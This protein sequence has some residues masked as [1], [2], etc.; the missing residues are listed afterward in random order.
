MNRQATAV[1]L[2]L[3]FATPALAHPGAWGREVTS[4][5][6]FPARA[7]RAEGK[8]E[9]STFV[10]EDAG[11]AARLGHGTIAMVPAPAGAGSEG[12]STVRV[13]EAALLDQLAMH[14]YDTASNSTTAVQTAEVRVIRDVAVPEEAPHKPVSGEMTLGVSNHGSMTGLALAVDLS[15]PRKAMISTRL[16]ARIRD[17][18]SGVVLWEGR[19]DLLARDGSDRWTDR[20]I[21]ERLAA[22]LFDRFPSA[23]RIAPHER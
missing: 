13:F 1:V 18:A 21:G 8:V 17:R 3:V 23:Q 16:E 7:E 15:K 22:A 10:S 11:A 2:A 5:S 12:E 20:T 4:E 9:A 6:R 19:A 14:G